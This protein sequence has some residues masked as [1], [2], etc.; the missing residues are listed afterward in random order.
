MPPVLREAALYAYLMKEH[1]FRTVADLELA[2]SGA[3]IAVM[4]EA[5]FHANYSP[6]ADS[7][8]PV[9]DVVSM[10]GGIEEV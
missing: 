9:T 5:A 2:W 10:F 4:V 8:K 7:D 3:L 1:G 6:P